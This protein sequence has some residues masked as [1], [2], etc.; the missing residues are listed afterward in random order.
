MGPAPIFVRETGLS[1]GRALERYHPVM[2]DATDAL[3]AS[4]QVRPCARCGNPAV[5]EVENGTHVEPV[6]TLHKAAALK[7]G[8]TMRL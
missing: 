5:C 2:S 8:W 6:C 1:T 3:Y 7:D 4:P